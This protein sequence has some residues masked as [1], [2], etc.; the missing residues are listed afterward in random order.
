MNIVES[1]DPC[2][3]SA[4]PPEKHRPERIRLLLVED[5]PG[6]IVLVQELLHE[7]AEAIAFEFSAA[8]SLAEAGEALQTGAIDIVLL[9]LTLPDVAGMET[10]RGMREFC[11]HTPVVILSGVNDEDLALRAVREGAQDYLNKNCLDPGSLIRTIRYALERHR[12]QREL[13]SARRA[14][15]HAQKLESLGVLTG[16]IAHDFNN[17]LGAIMGYAELCQ[18]GSPR[19]SKHRQYME[20]I[21]SGCRRGSELC[22]QMLAYAG[23]VEINMSVFELDTVINDL[24]GFMRVTVDR[25][26]EMRVEPGSDAGAIEA[27]VFQVRQILLNFLTNASEAIGGREGG[28]VSV[29]TGRKFLNAGEARRLHGDQARPGDYAWL[30][31]EDNGC[32]ID[33]EHLERIFDPFFTTKFEGRG[34][35]LSAVLGIINHHGGALEIESIPDLGSRFRAYFPV[36]EKAVAEEAP[37]YWAPESP[38][39]QTDARSKVLIA[40]D[41]AGMRDWLAAFFEGRGDEVIHARDGEEA[42]EQ[43]QRHRRQI[44]VALVDI[45]M[46][47]PST[48]RLFKTLFGIDPDLNLIVITGHSREEALQRLDGVAGHEPELLHKPLRLA[49][50]EASLERLGRTG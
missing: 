7:S 49:E 46:P 3:G 39:G 23:H 31:V 19:G 36:T 21:I 30:E 15:M 11:D 17:I 26:V 37:V 45:T 5:N 32:G 48:P 44:D 33:P 1:A 20:K 40:D 35:G 24:A 22:K 18:R 13:E 34:L 25:G 6:D 47:G 10:I 16:G 4:T 8:S 12:L 28:R 38:S 41:E 43:M 29:R 27:D 9:D 50:I 42:I 14:Q 2:E